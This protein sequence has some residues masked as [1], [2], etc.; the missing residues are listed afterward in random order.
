MSG[1]EIDEFHYDS[2]QTI[3][4][5]WCGVVMSYNGRRMRYDFNTWT[6]LEI[7]RWSGYPPMEMWHEDVRH[8]FFDDPYSISELFE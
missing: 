4:T 8:A 1:Q 2:D 5:Q 3:H 7:S 6:E